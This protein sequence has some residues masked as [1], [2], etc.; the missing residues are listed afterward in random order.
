LSFTGSDYGG[1]PTV[2]LSSSDATV[3]VPSTATSY[4]TITTSPVASEKTVTISA[5]YQGV[6]KT[7]AITLRPPQIAELW[8]STTRGT[9]CDYC[10]VYGGLEDLTGNVQL[11]AAAPS[12]GMPVKLTSSVQAAVQLPTVVVPAGETSY[13]FRIATTP[14]NQSTAVVIT[15]TAGRSVSRPYNQNPAL[16]GLSCSQPSPYG[17]QFTGTL[18]L[19]MTPTVDTVVVTLETSSADIAIVPESL[20]FFSGATDNQTF[21][22]TRGKVAGTVVIRAAYGDSKVSCTIAVN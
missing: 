10:P 4:F 7:L 12:G 22:V 5:S 15:A 2:T 16:S 6:Q 8:F 11:E 14:V 1:Q 18:S 3:Q 21:A 9:V 17:G 19:P 13:S 20:K